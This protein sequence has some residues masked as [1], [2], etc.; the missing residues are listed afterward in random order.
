MTPQ[1]AESYA[2]A[3]TLIS[4]RFAEDADLDELTRIAHA[5]KSH[6]G[7]SEL[8][9][10]RWRDELTFTT[11]SIRAMSTWVAELLGKPVGVAQLRRIPR[12]EL[13]SLW[14]HPEAIGQGVGRLL[15]DTVRQE[16]RQ[17]GGQ[18]LFIDADP[19]AE[20]F[21]QRMGAVRV[22]ETAAPIEA[23][24]DRV[25]PMLLLKLIPLITVDPL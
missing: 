13:E 10:W 4:I 15:V 5:S 14:V 16:A 24:P 3:H 23:D 25:R 1:D 20:V 17:T 11:E 21:Y 7:Y 12:L 18:E 2:S 6:W 22:G 8:D 19:N 9:L